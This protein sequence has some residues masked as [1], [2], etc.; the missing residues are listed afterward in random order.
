MSDFLACGFEPAAG[1]E[2]HATVR[3]TIDAERYDAL[4]RRGPAPERLRAEGFAKDSKP[5]HFERWHDLEGARTYRSPRNGLFYRLEED[6][7]LIT[8]LAREP[9]RHGRLGLMRVARELAM[10]HVIA[11]GGSLLHASAVARGEDVIAFAGPRRSGKTTLLLA[12]LAA[13]R[14][15]YVANDRAVLRVTGGTATLRGLATLV[16]IRADT[17]DFFPELSARRERLY[18]RD[19]GREK[20][21]SLTPPELLEVAGGRDSRAAGRL[22]ALVLPRIGGPPRA[23]L[24]ARAVAGPG[25]AAASLGPLSR[26]PGEPAGRGLRGAP[27]T[28]RGPGPHARLARGP[29]ALLRMRTRRRPA[30]ERD[31]A[32]GTPG[33]AAGRERRCRVSVCRSS[34]SGPTR[35]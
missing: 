1:D 20:P 21:K 29:R 26:R 8:L 12:L 28:A 34:S 3:L 7:A 27:A 5:D 10:E 35:A 22:R 14:V 30:A 2:P 9:T 15:S 32:R 17:L 25:A 31:R 23:R 11:S 4:E 18:P 24:P 16:S 33:D 13:G 19:P 6:G